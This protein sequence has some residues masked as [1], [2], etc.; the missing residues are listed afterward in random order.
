MH[1]VIK[2]ASDGMYLSQMMNIDDIG[3]MPGMTWKSS[4]AYAY[5]FPDL[6]DARAYLAYLRGYY[7]SVK[8]Y[9]RNK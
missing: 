8:I 1:W 9:R 5:Q 3:Y 4:S 6:S 7:L 2:D